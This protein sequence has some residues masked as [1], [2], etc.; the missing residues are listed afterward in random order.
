M[1]ARTHPT[2]ATNGNGNG[3]L[4]PS[5]DDLILAYQHGER[6][7]FADYEAVKSTY[8]HHNGPIKDEFYARHIDGTGAVLIQPPGFMN[9]VRGV[10]RIRLRYDSVLTAGVQPA[11]EAALWRARALERESGLVLGGRSRQVLVEMIF[12]IVTYLL[13]VLDALKPTGDLDSPVVRKRI[14]AALAAVTKELERLD[15]FAKSAARKASLRFYLL[16]LPL[17]GL[18]IVLLIWAARWLSIIG[19]P[20]TLLRICLTCGGIGAIVS[21]MVRI[22][23]G[24][25]IYI[26]SQQGHA[27][28]VLAGS[29]RPV[30][31]AVFGAAL[32]VFMEGDLLPIARPDAAA[33]DSYFFAGLA[34]LA[35]FSERWAQDTIVR[36]IPSLPSVGHDGLA[37]GPARP[38]SRSR[39]EPGARDVDDD[40]RDA[41]RGL[42]RRS[43]AL[44]AQKTRPSRG[45]SAA[46]VAGDR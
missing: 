13:G 44:P 46:P 36:S 5:L 35:G 29:F 32:Y 31:G 42:E 1:V 28:T 37:P 12:V 8:Q 25:N 38:G 45:A 9:S 40:E 21:V 7:D 11:F 22:T 20:P 33:D 16:G 26:D 3:V 19:T 15:G 41:G 14:E 27:V 18:A 2:R 23:R 6:T 24:Q 43:G 39:S 30:I 17:G 34:F 4:P 10:R